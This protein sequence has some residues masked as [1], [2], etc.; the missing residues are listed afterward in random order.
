MTRMRHH[1]K[2]LSTAC[3][4]NTAPDAR[5]VTNSPESGYNRYIVA[6]CWRMLKQCSGH[7]AVFRGVLEGV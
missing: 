1:V 6:E 3:M 2:T 4:C 7:P 5:L